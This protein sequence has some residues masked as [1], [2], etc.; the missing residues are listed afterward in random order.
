M[1][2]ITKIFEFAAGHHLPYHEGLC[3]NRHG[4]NFR[5]EIT[6]GTKARTL[7]EESVSPENWPSKGMIMDFKTLKEIVNQKVTDLLDHQYLN[8][9]IPNPTAELLVLY[10]RGLILDEIS[11]YGILMKVRLWES[12]T[13]YTEWNNGL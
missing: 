12:S 3:K 13:S 7:M 6:V 4:H 8:D 9:H 10:I 11:K 2:T 5:L 1:I